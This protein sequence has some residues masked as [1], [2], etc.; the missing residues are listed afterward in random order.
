[1]YN[2]GCIQYTC[3]VNKES[4]NG[5]EVRTDTCIC[6]E[7]CTFL[8]HLCW[9]TPLCWHSCSAACLLIPQTLDSHTSA[10]RLLASSPAHVY[11][12][13]PHTEC[14]YA[15]RVRIIACAACW[16]M[17]VLCILRIIFVL[18]IISY[19]VLSYPGSKMG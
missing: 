12:R 18:C 14:E 19:Y 11:T 9:E 4:T 17:A 8:L 16:Q 5:K 15:I 10:T 13:A 2:V 3:I 7:Y 6:I 1:M